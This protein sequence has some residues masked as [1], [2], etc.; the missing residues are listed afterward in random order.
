MKTKLRKRNGIVRG[1]KIILLAI[2]LQSFVLGIS[3]VL[4]ANDLFP[5][6]MVD[7]VNAAQTKAS[8]ISTSGSYDGSSVSATQEESDED[9]ATDENEQ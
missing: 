4:R 3:I 2:L 5:S 1:V 8:V 7:D 9:A 6:N